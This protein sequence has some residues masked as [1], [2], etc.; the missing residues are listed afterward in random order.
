MAELNTQQLSELVRKLQSG[1]GAAF[2]EIYEATRQPAYFTA[3]K[4]AKNEQDA[5]DILQEAYIQLLDKINTLE[6]PD[7][8]VKWFNRIVANKAKD[9]LKKKNPLLFKDAEA[10]Q[11][12][13][14]EQED[15]DRDFIPEDSMDKTELRREMMKIIDGLNDDQRACILLYYYDE[16]PVKEI[17]ASLDVSESAVKSRLF[18]ARKEIKAQVEAL[19]KQNKALFG[20][21]PMPLVIWALKTAGA[22]AAASS[23]ASGAAAATLAAVTATAG[24]TAAVAASAGTAA[25]AGGAAAKAIGAGVAQKLIAGLLAAT[26]IGGG[27]FAGTQIA[28]KVKA[29]AEKEKA[30]VTTAVDERNQNS[31]QEALTE[32]PTEAPTVPDGKLADTI[33]ET[34]E[35]KYG[36]TGNFQS[37]AIR[38]ADGTEVREFDP[39]LNYAQ[40]D[41]D[42]DD[43]LPAARENMQTY[44]AE[45]T[46]VLTEINA[47]RLAN[48][49]T[50]VTEDPVLAETA[51][52]RAEE[53]AWSGKDNSIRPDGS[54]YTSA[55]DRNGY[56]D[57]GRYESR[58]TG[59]SSSTEAMKRLTGVTQ[60]DATRIGVGVAEDPAGRGNVYVVHLYAP[61]GEAEAAPS[62]TE[63]RIDQL[64]ESGY[65][66][67]DQLLDT[68]RS[69][70]FW[71]RMRE[72]PVLREIANY[73]FHNDELV[74]FRKM[75]EE[76]M[77]NYGYD[78]IDQG[79]DLINRINETGE[80]EE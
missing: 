29:N 40:F 79:Y 73:D 65:E 5:E 67:K 57:G 17:A 22:A 54:S 12:Y 58:A 9:F 2:N 41:A 55:F 11:F 15:D 71:D 27:T 24:G 34:R 47:K 49:L 19:A 62:A 1:D 16:M 48:G 13:T 66:A 44:A 26:L 43:L 38:T 74:L 52:V 72:F 68:E 77:L 39:V 25:T 59:A 76:R 7:T 45:R 69:D 50:P 36:V 61:E 42:Y 10:E 14:E 21:A 35:L 23:A 37:F 28:K 33:I 32:A 3:L 60:G 53:I 18:H 4:I 64:Y 30:A 8:F 75:I 51:S 46:S 31:T 70:A 63:Q 78:L 80:N 56:Y 6:N 20:V